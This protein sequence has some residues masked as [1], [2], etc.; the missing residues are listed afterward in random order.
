[1][2]SS[3][4]KIDFGNNMISDLG[5]NFSL[6]SYLF[7][8]GDL[9]ETRVNSIYDG[10]GTTYNK[11][12]SNVKEITDYYAITNTNEIYYINDSG[13]KGSIDKVT[14]NGKKIYDDYYQTSDGKFHYISYSGAVY[15][16]DIEKE[17]IKE[18]LYGK[19]LTKLVYIDT[20]NKLVLST[21]IETKKL[22]FNPSSMKEVYDFIK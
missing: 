14:D 6:S 11:I 8:N 19:D 13:F 5:G 15:I 1:M 9:Y 3:F 2:A 18:M 21:E 12:L 7:S 16:K 17:N 10:K 20:N 22:D 4:T